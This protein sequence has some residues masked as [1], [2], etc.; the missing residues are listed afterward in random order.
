MFTN[1]FVEHLSLLMR[2]RMKKK[3]NRNKLSLGFQC[4]KHF[5]YLKQSFKKNISKN[6]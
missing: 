1:A 5:S 4:L 6:I 3:K 2:K